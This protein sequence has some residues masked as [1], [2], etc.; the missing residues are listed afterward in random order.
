MEKITQAIKVNQISYVI[1]TLEAQKLLHR[2]LQK[3]AF[4]DIQ[5]ISSNATKYDV[6]ITSL[7]C[8]A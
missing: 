2:L 7:T 6:H 1:I 8:Q 4:S 5:R 3:T